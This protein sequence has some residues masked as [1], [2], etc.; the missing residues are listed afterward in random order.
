M[1]IASILAGIT[2][3]LVSF[4]VTLILGHGVLWAL[5]AYAVMGLAGALVIIAIGAL[6]ASRPKPS[7]RPTMVHARN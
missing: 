4:G 2:S 3:G 6:R 7:Y 5:A 1:A